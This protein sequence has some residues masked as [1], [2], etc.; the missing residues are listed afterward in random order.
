[1]GP[2]EP[3]ATSK[4]GLYRDAIRSMRAGQLAA[5][6]RRLLP[7]RLLAA[8][9]ERGRPA[10]WRPLPPG[11]IADPAPQ[12]GPTPPPDQ[13]R[14]FRAFG[15]ERRFGEA[16]FWA[17]R[18][19]GLLFAFHLH[20]F[21]DLA[22]YAVGARTAEASAFWAEVADDWLDSNSRPGAPGW[23][24]YPTSERL[25]AWSVAISAIEEW[26]AE[27]RDRIAREI[28]RQARYLTRTVEHDIGGNH[29]LRNATAIALAGTLYPDSR[30]ADRGLRLLERELERQ[31]LADGGHEERSPSY[32][33]RISGEL[34]GLAAILEAGGGAPPWLG[35]AAASTEAWMRRIA[36][37]D[38]SLP[39]LNDA[40]SGPP[41]GSTARGRPS[42]TWPRAAMSSLASGGDRAVLDVGPVCPPHL[43]AHAH[44]D[45]LSFVLWADGEQVLVDPGTYLY[46]GPERGRFRGTAAHST[47]EV[48]G[49]TNATSGAI[50][51]PRDGRTSPSAGSNRVTG[52][53][54]STPPTTATAGWP[55]RSSTGA[56]SPGCREAGSSSSTGSTVSRRT[57][58]ARPFGRRTTHRP[59]AGAS[60]RSRSRPSAAPPRLAC[61]PIKSPPSWAR[62]G[63]PLPSRTAGRWGRAMCLDGAS[64]GTRR[65]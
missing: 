19:D 44:A 5:R 2:A 62:C 38:G 9:C 58:S 4:A 48:D 32:H 61:A 60:G 16:G 40:W 33:R 49:G 18:S 46:S 41:C 24:P 15:I 12:S 10:S 39:L 28:W 27:L 20:G 29:V 23:H 22:N 11:W 56:L 34:A 54:S 37:P 51:A 63:L 1:M 52:P 47:V 21:S 53:R 7:P 36:G 50:S 57:G 26:P 14:R 25:I 45:V 59:R 8:G 43:P 6:T 31:I 3:T 17:E 30:L 13:D 35:E 55:I 65:G 64:C 42:T